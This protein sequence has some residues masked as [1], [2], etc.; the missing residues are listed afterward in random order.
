LD[1][2]NYVGKIKFTAGYEEI[3]ERPYIECTDNGIGMAEQHLSRLF[4]HGDRRFAESHEFQVKRAAWAIED[5]PFY[6]NSRFGV[7]V[8]SYFMLADQITV[9]TSRL[10]KDAES[11]GPLLAATIQGSNS[12]K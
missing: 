10:E 12:M 11:R 2:N 8:L 9:T 5:I 1:D 4:A 6:P 3:T 7:G